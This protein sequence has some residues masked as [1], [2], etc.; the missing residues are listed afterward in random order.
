[1]HGHDVH[2]TL[3]QNCNIH[4]F[5]G[6][7]S[8]PGPIMTCSENVLNLRK[9]GSLFSYKPDKNKTH[10]YNPHQTKYLNEEIPVIEFHSS[11]R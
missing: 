1:M 11:R 10:D 9:P 5:L 2:E 3:Y 6:R 4:D 8:G 7:C